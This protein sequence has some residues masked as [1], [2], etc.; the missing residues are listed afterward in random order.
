MREINKVVTSTVTIEGRETVTIA[1]KPRELY[2]ATEVTDALPGVVAHVWLDETGDALKCVTDDGFEDGLRHA[3]GGA[4]RGD[5]ARPDRPG[6]A[7]HVPLERE[8]RPAGPGQGGALPDRRLHRESEARGPASEDREPGSRLG[9]AA[10]EGARRRGGTFGGEARAEIPRGLRV[11]AERR[12]GYSAHGARE[13]LALGL[14][15]GEGETA[16]RVGVQVY[17]EEGLQRRLRLGEGDVALA[18]GRLQGA[19]HAARRAAAGGGNPVARGR[20]R[21]LRG[22]PVHQ[23]HVDRGVPQRLDRPRRHAVGRRASWMPPTSSWPPA[24]WTAPPPTT[25]HSSWR[26]RR[27]TTSRSSFRSSKEEFCLCWAPEYQWVRSR[28]ARS[29]I[30][31]R[32]I[33]PDAGGSVRKTEPAIL[34][35]HRTSVQRLPSNRACGQNGLCWWFLLKM[36][37]FIFTM[38]VAQVVDGLANLRVPPLWPARRPGSGLLTRP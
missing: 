27:S 7:V 12:P 11:P 23:P 19:L 16:R 37:S 18:R 1:G 24:P 33:E 21:H 10:R 34:R 38:N 6:E 25:P 22:W 4:A 36:F 2:K 8:I 15:G 32:P 31:R 13:R 26:R 5:L 14:P 28:H 30:S 3:R 9:A 29:R 17:H 20:R 35:S